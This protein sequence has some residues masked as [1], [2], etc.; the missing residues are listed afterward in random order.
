LFSL[1]IYTCVRLDYA[2]RKKNDHCARKNM[3]RTFCRRY[4][5]VLLFDRLDERRNRESLAQRSNTYAYRKQSQGKN[6]TVYVRHCHTECR[7]SQEDYGDND[8][9]IQ[10]GCKKLTVIVRK[11]CFLN[12]GNHQLIYK[13]KN[14]AENKQIACIG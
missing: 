6:K 4:F 9:E 11:I 3:E 2:N 13:Q 10:C 14:T 8:W 12:Q 7:G 5:R 1:K